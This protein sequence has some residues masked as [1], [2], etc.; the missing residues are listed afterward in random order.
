PGVGAGLRGAVRDGL[1]APITVEGVRG[2]FL[3]H[4]P[5][6]ERPFEP[7]TTL[8][9]PFDRLVGR[10]DPL[11][12]RRTGRLEVRA[13]YAEPDAPADA[14]PRVAAAIHELARW[15]GAERIAFGRRVP[16]RW[17]VALRSVS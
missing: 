2:Q 10:V 3:A 16:P 6:L 14:G 9:S 15:L 13:V 7:R 11:F 17:R 4:L 12:D 1:A 5:T 8:L